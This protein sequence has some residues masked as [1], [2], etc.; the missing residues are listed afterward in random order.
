MSDLNNIVDKLKYQRTA[1]TQYTTGG[2]LVNNAKKE[3]R[4]RLPDLAEDLLNALAIFM[5]CNDLSLFDDEELRLI[6]NTGLQYLEYAGEVTSL[7]KKLKPGQISFDAGG[8]IINQDIQFAE[9]RNYFRRAIATNK[10]LSYD[11]QTMFITNLR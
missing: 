7:P 9:L 6:A 8:L 3:L 1:N 10:S 11:F 2:A 5:Q 4:Q